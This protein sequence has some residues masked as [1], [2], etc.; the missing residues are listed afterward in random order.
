VR[1]IHGRPD[2]AKTEQWGATFYGTVWAEP[3]QRL[4]PGDVVW[5]P[6]GERHWHGASV[7]CAMSHVAISLGET[8]WETPVSEDDY[9]AAQ[10]Q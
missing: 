3:P 2:G 4:R 8:R 9:L 6:P 7:G 5:V 10:Q 1:I